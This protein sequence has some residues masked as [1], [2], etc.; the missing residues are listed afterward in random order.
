MAK[1]R[2]QL[3]FRIQNLVPFIHCNWCLAFNKTYQGSQ[4]TLSLYQALTLSLEIV[5]L[6]DAT[7]VFV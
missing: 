3:R 1:W 5:N 2:Q 6:N 4:V 7:S